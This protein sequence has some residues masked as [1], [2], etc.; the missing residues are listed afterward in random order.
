MHL[1][2][3]TFGLATLLAERKHIHK[4][5]SVVQKVWETLV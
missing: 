4:W 5:G 3:K 2:K 1:A